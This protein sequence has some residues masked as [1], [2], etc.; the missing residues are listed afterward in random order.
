MCGYLQLGMF[1]SHL[2][3]ANILA[4]RYVVLLVCRMT[5]LCACVYWFTLFLHL[6][7][8]AEGYCKQ[9]IQ[10]LEGACGEESPEVLKVIRS[11]V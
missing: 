8:S 4:I 3:M 6:C 10:T 2:Q 11:H 5:I 7:S 1:L 9:A